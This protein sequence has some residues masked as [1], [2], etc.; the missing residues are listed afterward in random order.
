[1]ESKN[2]S[3]VGSTVGSPKSPVSSPELSVGSPKS[4]IASPKSPIASPRSP[5]GS[6]Q[7]APTPP[8]SGLLPENYWI[9]APQTD[10]NGLEDI[11]SSTASISS[12]VL[13]YRTVN[14]RTY[15]STRGN[16]EYW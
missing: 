8:T 7:A 3:P 12:S 10:D 14:G 2:K 4:P 9:D 1:M 11:A 13:H 5:A 6:P 15:H 16:A